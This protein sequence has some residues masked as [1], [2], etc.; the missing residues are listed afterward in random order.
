VTLRRLVVVLGDQ[1][2]ADSAA[3]DDF[4]PACDAVWMAEVPAESTH[5]WSHKARIALFLGAMRHFRERLRSRGWTVHYRELGDANEA[6]SLGVALGD[7]LRRLRPERAIVVE[8]G[9]W[10]VARELEA[11]AQSTGTRLDVWP[12]RHFLSAPAD[13]AAWAKGRREL[14]LEYWYRLLRRRTGLLMDGDAPAGGQWNYDA[15]NRV[16]FGA[17]GPGT[18]PAPRAFPPDAL[19]REVLA[20]VERRFANHPGRLERF[21]WP[22]TPEDARAALDDFVAHRLPLFG[23]YQDALWNG[24]TWLY[25]SRLS[26]AMNLKLLHP[27]VACEA[28][29]AAWRE[30]RAPIA[31]VEGFVRQIL[32]WREY[33]RGL[34]WLRMPAYLDDN[35]LAAHEALPAF[36]WT[37]DT[38]AECLRDALAQTLEHGYSHHIQR[39][40][41]TGLYALLLGVEPRRVHEWYLAVYVDAVEWVELPNTLGMS[42][43]A[44]GGVMAS[45]PYAAS[46]KYVDRMSNHCSRC[47]YRPDEAVGERAC[48]FTT[49]YWDF[50]DRH[51]QRF[52]SHPR[53]ALQ[54]KNLQRLPDERR[55]AIRERAAAIRAGG[56]APAGV[57]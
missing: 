39:L 33:V 6:P 1:L 22:V 28:A 4:D 55:A 10:R 17:K 53:L 13:F 52:A 45:K 48:P 15:E 2:D 32:G 23:R 25:H 21:D 3:F 5:V 40:M 56:G 12:D 8:P 30:G 50:L 14:R 29:E 34:Y 57:P 37:A 19:T 46:G 38:D 9:E 31:A 20:L 26:A 42:Q 54:V 44:D 49:L 43:Y 35:A 18:L 11:A 16:G 24:E 36:Y 51:E 47:R 27:R 7:D 41:V